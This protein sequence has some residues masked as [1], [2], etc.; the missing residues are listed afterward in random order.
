MSPK[1]HVKRGDI[2]IV[3]SGANKGKSGKILEI[4][5]DRQRARVEGLALIKRHVKKSSDKNA[6]EG[7]I[8]TREGSIHISNLKLQT[9]A[10]KEKPA[11]KSKDK[12]AAKEKPAKKSGHQESRQNGQRVIA[13][14]NPTSKVEPFST[15]TI[16]Q[17]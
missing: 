16:S 2:V 10:V 12:S 9:A 13:T 3:I 11:A 7:G 4:L 15:F 6:Q 8:I 17:I 14:E 1:F 5:A